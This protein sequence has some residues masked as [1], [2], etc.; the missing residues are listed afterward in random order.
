GLMQHNTKQVLDQ[1]P[2]LGSMPILGALFR[3]RDFQNDETELVV[4]ISAYLVTPAAQIKLASPTDGFV[5]PGDAET[6]LMGRLNAVYSKRN[7]EAIK[8]AA[9]GNAGYIVQ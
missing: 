7:P 8:S 5:P 2:G 9:A 6:I 1:F 3:S 4:V